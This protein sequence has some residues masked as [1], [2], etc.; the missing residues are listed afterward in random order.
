MPTVEIVSR[1]VTL[2]LANSSS[3]DCLTETWLNWR[4][5]NIEPMSTFPKS[6]PSSSFPD[7]RFHTQTSYPD[8]L[9]MAKHSCVPVSQKTI[10]FGTVVAVCL[11]LHVPQSIRS[12]PATLATE[13]PP[14]DSRMGPKRLSFQEQSTAAR[15]FPRH[16][17]PSTS[18]SYL[19][20]SPYTRKL[21]TAPCLP[22]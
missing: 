11:S 14:T 22:N 12:F 17:P 7:G 9:Q 1:F 4:Q 21:I 2:S 15:S 20:H 19:I 5:P 13:F 16:P 6:R 18:I 3:I 8:H 10:S